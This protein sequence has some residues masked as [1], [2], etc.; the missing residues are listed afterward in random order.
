MRARQIVGWVI[1]LVAAAYAV[2]KIRPLLDHFK[3]NGVAILLLVV[4]AGI[5]VLAIA[6]IL[7]Y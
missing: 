4:I 5:L 2:T 3:G 1:L 7:R 6:R